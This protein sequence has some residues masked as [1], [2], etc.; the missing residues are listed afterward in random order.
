MMVEQRDIDI[1]AGNLIDWDFFR[2]K[3]V[4]VTGSTGRIGMY[5]VEA[6][7]DA[8]IRWNLGMRIIA[9]ARNFDKLQ[10]VFGNT[11]RF[12]NVGTLI[13]DI[14]EPIAIDDGVDV[15]FHIAGAAAPVNFTNSPVET[16]WGHVQGTRNVLEL[17]RE[18]RSE[19]IF[20][21][22]TVE[23]YGELGKNGGLRETDMG[24][25]RHDNAR[26]C[27]PEA[28][29][30]CETMLASYAAEYGVSYRG[31]RLSHTFGPGIDLNDGRAFAEF[32]RN[33]VRGEDIV[34]HS[35]GSAVRPYTYVADVIGAMFLVATKGESNSFYNVANLANMVSIKDLAE[36][37]AG[38][39]PEK[40]IHV[41]ILHQETSGLK[42]LPF[43]LGIMNVDKIMRLGWKPQVDLKT[44]FRYTL[45]SLLQDMS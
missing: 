43:Q 37:I 21:V 4:L 24:I 25:L 33:V 15:I 41:R 3:T 20:Y 1:I 40:N 19:Q 23:I 2:G 22:S 9:M 39:C 17:A 6:L 28:K 36:M 11:L 27:Y 38:L 30:L 18:K 13:Q 44:A 45:D 16:L 32:L 35:D 8:D 10:K 42:F 34:L 14:T 26:A 7:C 12:P 31:V 29:R 5:V